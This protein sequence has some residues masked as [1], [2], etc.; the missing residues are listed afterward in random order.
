MFL[1][2]CQCWERNPINNI[3]EEK[4]WFSPLVCNVGCNTDMHLVFSFRFDSLTCLT[5]LPYCSFFD[6]WM[7]FH[8]QS[9]QDFTLMLGMRLFSLRRRHFDSFFAK[10]FLLQNDLN[11]ILCLICDFIFLILQHCVCILL[12]I[13]AWNFLS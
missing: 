13:H 1:N 12:S 3:Q 11:N 8:Y 7:G 10:M 6:R 5:F 9:V 2:K 4:H